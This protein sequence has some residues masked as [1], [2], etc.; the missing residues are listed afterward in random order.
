MRLPNATLRRS[1]CTASGNGASASPLNC[2]ASV[3]KGVANVSTGALAG[4]ELAMV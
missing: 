3:L 4:S 2:A 1:S